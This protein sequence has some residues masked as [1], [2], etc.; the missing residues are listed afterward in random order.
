MIQRRT[1]PL[2][3]DQKPKLVPNFLADLKLEN[4]GMYQGRPVV[5]DYGNH[6]IYALARG[7]HRM[8]RGRWHNGKAG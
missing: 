5:H 4:W 8:I 6:A 1:T 7:R 3:E 2:R